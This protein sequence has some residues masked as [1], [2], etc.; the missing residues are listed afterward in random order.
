[1]F[2]LCSF[3]STFSIDGRT[4][5]S[6]GVGPHVCSHGPYVG[7]LGAYVGSL[8]P[9]LGPML[10]ILGADQGLSW[11]SWAACR[12]YV[13][14]LGPLSGPLWAVLG[15]YQ[16]LCGRSWPLSE[17]MWAVLGGERSK[18][19]PNASGKPIRAGDQGRKGVGKVEKWPK[20]ERECDLGRGSGPTGDQGRKE[21]GHRRSRRTR[22]VPLRIFSI[23][24]IL[25][26]TCW[27]T[28]SHRTCLAQVMS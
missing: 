10:A 18:S 21:A 28:P 25:A 1:M 3:S 2:C 4:R 23:D 11:R 26:S 9:L 5:S 7:C 27:L 6:R 19:G 8:G 13:G 24:Y 22:R 15:C 16:G 20:S 12:A 17:P 14:G